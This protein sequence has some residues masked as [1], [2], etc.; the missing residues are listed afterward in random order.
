GQ[1]GKLH[2]LFHGIMQPLLTHRKRRYFMGFGLIVLIVAMMGLAVVQAVVM[3]MLPF[4]N[5]SEIKLV[6]DMPE[7]SSLEQ[8][9]AVLLQMAQKLDEVEEVTATQIYAGTSSPI[10]FN[11]L[12]RQY[13]LRE[14]AHMGDIQ[15]TLAHARERDRTSH[16]IAR[17]L[18]PLL[19]PIAAAAGAALKVVE[20]PPG[21]PVLAPIVAE[22]Y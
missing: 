2:R 4:D 21:P 10:G 9:N 1:Q 5:K 20:V 15:V 16:D 12:V 22:V 13:Y 3:K 19:D 18:R 11:G 8:T 14:S 17:S 6:L 7:G